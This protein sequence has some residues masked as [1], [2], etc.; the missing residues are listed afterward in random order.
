MISNFNLSKWP[1]VYFKSLG[2]N[3]DDESFEEY[4]KYY[5]NLLIRC[6]NTNEKMILICNLNKLTSYPIEFIYKQVEFSKQIFKFNQEYLKCVCILCENRNFKNILNLFFTLVKPSSPYKL[7]KN[8]DKVNKYLLE[9]FNI[10]F[11]SNV[12]DDSIHNDLTNEE[13][14]NEEEVDEE[15]NEEEMYKEVKQ[16]I[17]VGISK[18]L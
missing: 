4:K 18:D 3:I 12:L 16:E 6:K 7:C 11:N 14:V 15:V 13:E 2:N 17:K 10:T 5:L 9:V 1:I 8:F